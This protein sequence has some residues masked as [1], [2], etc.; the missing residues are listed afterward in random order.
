MLGY[1]FASK[2]IFCWLGGHFITF[3]S[4]LLYH[5]QVCKLMSASGCNSFSLL[6]FYG[7]RIILSR[8][9]KFPFVPVSICHFFTP[10]F[11]EKSK[12][13]I[14]SSSLYVSDPNPSLGWCSFKVM[15]DIDVLLPI[16]GASFYVPDNFIVFSDSGVQRETFSDARCNCTSRWHRPTDLNGT[17]YYFFSLTFPFSLI[18]Q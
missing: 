11:C 13:F 7:S 9:H 6:F 8:I 2:L 18:F 3:I 16:M 5:S 15:E 17:C 14:I 1:I 4:L 12:F 10:I